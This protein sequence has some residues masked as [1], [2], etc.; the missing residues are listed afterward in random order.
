LRKTFCSL[1]L[2]FAP[3]ALELVP[4][5]VDEVPPAR[6]SSGFTEYEAM[7]A[8]LPD[9]TLLFRQPGS[10]QKACGLASTPSKLPVMAP[11]YRRRS[12]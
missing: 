4:A 7:D 11:S 12:M 6:R 5:G 2:G 8:N 9:M 1:R 3:V 10:P